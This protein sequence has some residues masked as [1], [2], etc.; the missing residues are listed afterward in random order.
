VPVELRELPGTFHTFTLVVPQAQVSRR[1]RAEWAAALRGAFA[2]I[3][4]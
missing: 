1:Q 4:Q 3:R 2:P